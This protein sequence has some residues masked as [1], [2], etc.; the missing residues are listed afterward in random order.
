MSDLAMYVKAKRGTNGWGGDEICGITSAGFQDRLSL[1]IHSA[2]LGTC[3]DSDAKPRTL[4]LVTW[5]ARSEEHS[6]RFCA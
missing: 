5:P 1:G 2:N 4:G 3:R 6:A